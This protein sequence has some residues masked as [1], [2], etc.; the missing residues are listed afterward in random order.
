[1]DNQK[2]R[3]LAERLGFQFEGILRQVWKLHGQLV[4]HAAY[5]MLKSDWMAL[6]ST[7]R[8]ES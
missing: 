6:Q 3:V 2:S 7:S 4:D 8:A 1:V 5:A